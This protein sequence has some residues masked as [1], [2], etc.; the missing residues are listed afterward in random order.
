MPSSWRRSQGGAGTSQAVLSY[1]AGGVA[2]MMPHAGGAPHRPPPQQ[3]PAQAGGDIMRRRLRRI[4]GGHQARV[5][6]AT[7]TVVGAMDCSTLVNPYCSGLDYSQ[8][9][10][11]CL[12][13][14]RSLA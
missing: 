12:P 11:L 8:A 13:W 9:C 6:T 14:P 5:S 10:G 3:Q 1:L 2:M 4:T 7:W